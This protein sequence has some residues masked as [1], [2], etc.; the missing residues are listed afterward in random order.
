MSININCI[1]NDRGAWCKNK[2]IRRSLC[3]IGA[4]CCLEFPYISD[5]KKC[6]FKKEF[7]NPIKSIQRF[8]WFYGKPRHEGYY[9]MKRKDDS[10]TI[11][12]IYT[13]FKG[14]ELQFV[15]LGND[16]VFEYKELKGCQWSGPIKKENNG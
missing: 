11:C 13:F 8:K 7:K 10:I 14:E 6:L 12:E 16:I 3:G 4:R 2:N 5:N 1:S 15:F 9:W